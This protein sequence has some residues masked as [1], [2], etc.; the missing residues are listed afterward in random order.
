MIDP[1]DPL[2]HL[3][4]DLSADDLEATV[5]V[6]EVTLDELVEVGPEVEI[7]SDS[8]VDELALLVKD[9]QDAGTSSDEFLAGLGLGE[10]SLVADLDE[11]VVFDL[12]ENGLRV[13]RR[14]AEWEGLIPPGA[15]G[16]R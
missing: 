11:G 13:T 1:N 6:H 9:R 3:Y 2:A 8:D 12:N 7:L 14:L 15:T 10:F 4:A 5:P 16:I